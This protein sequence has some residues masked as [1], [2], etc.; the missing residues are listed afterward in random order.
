MAI[1]NY[2][3]FL[4][5]YDKPTLDGLIVGFS[6]IDPQKKTSGDGCGCDNT[7]LTDE[8][9]AIVNTQISNYL[10]NY[11]DLTEEQL[12]IINN[13]IEERIN[14][15]ELPEEL[16]NSL[17]A[18]YV[19]RLTIRV[20]S[21]NVDPEAD[22]YVEPTIP[23]D[24]S[25]VDH[26]EL[27]G[28]LGGNIG[29]HYHLTTAERKKLELMIKKFFPNGDDEIIVTDNPV[30]PDDPDNPKPEPDDPYGGLPAGT[31][32]S[33][34]VHSLPTSYSLTEAAHKMYYGKN[35]L[36]TMGTY[37]DDGL[38]VAMK[39][40]NNNAIMYTTDLENWQR[41][42]AGNEI[43]K[44]GIAQ[45]YLDEAGVNQ[46]AY[47][48]TSLTVVKTPGLFIIS[49]QAKGN[50]NFDVLT[51]KS[52]VTSATAFNTVFYTIK[53][54]PSNIV[55]S[56]NA[57]EIAITYSPELQMFLF[58]MAK[59][60]RDNEDTSLYY[61]NG[62]AVCYRKKGESKIYGAFDIGI[63]PNPGCAAWAPTVQL[64]CV[65]GPEGVATSVDGQTWAIHRDAPH[66]LV[67]LTYREDLQNFFARSA[68]EK[69]F[70][71]SANGWE[72]EKV[73]EVP[74]PLENV[75]A[76]TYSPELKWYCAVGKQ[77][78]NACFSKDLKHWINTP[79]RYQNLDIADIIYMPS[80]GLFVAMPTSGT[81][82]YTFNPAAWNNS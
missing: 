77:T 27:G 82:F 78:F 70:Y 10:A 24:P 76:V 40:S 74:I 65:T 35:I 7:I 14:E 22:D 2:D 46:S 67:D 55:S 64:F 17:I 23:L 45:W 60:T 43:F 30:E 49:S 69:I 12:E 71:V 68:D 42:V 19:A 81:Y 18:K 50:H 75:S 4:E 41:V 47:S 66:N 11:G 44:N 26:E 56:D 20:D 5:K 28:L 33:W 59:Y 25:D 15:L 51:L 54:N 9:K 6:G 36:A 29:G 38:H 13:I 34:A 37:P 1:N 3:E 39:Y 32:P 16:I 62:G 58:I 61:P 52:T 8:Q 57:T 48:G 53:G 73:S 63:T 79:I 31:P 72:W 21:G 80:T